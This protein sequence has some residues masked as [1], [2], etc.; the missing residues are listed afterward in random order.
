MRA[1]H[2]RLPDQRIH[3]QAAV[4]LGRLRAE[5]EVDLVVQQR[6]D[7]LAC[8]GDVA[9]DAHVSVFFP[10]KKMADQI[11]DVVFRRRL[12]VH[13]ADETVALLV[14]ALRRSFGSAGGGEDFLR[15]GEEDFSLLREVQCAPFLLKKGEAEL[16]LE[17]PDR[18]R[19]RRLGDHQLRRGAGELAGFG[20]CHK[21][22]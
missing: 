9:L 4:R 16:I 11:R 5:A 17:L 12:R 18:L 2:D 20:D 19:E 3:E 10:L 1:E 21:V 22:L 13:E 7:D 15:V 8:A 6:A 14:D